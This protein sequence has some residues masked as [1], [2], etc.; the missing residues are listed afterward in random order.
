MIGIFLIASKPTTKFEYSPATLN[1][2]EI[3]KFDAAKSKVYKAIYG[4]P[5]LIQLPNQYSGFDLS[6]T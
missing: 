3:V 1:T 6:G 4:K 2:G 5:L